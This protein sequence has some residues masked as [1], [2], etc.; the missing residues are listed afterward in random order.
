MIYLIFV[1][2]IY[3]RKK[4][5]KVGLCA[6]GKLE[7]LY[8]KE[9]VNYYKKLGYKHIYIYDNNN[10]NE[11]KF[12]TVL[13]EDIKKGFVTI[14]DYRGF[15]GSRD[16]PQFD[17]YYDCYEKYNKEYDWLSFFDF[18]EFL[19][20]KPNNI[21]IYEFLENER[22]NNCISVKINWLLY[23]DN[24][25]IYYE[26]LPIQSRFLSPLTNSSLNIHI[27]STVRGNLTI[28]YWKDAQNPHTTIHQYK[29]CSS[30]GKLIPYNS[31]FNS[32]PDYNN[33]ILRH[34]KTKTIDEY[35][36]KLK[37]GRADKPLNF[38]EEDSLEKINIFF[39]V[40]E[41]KMSKIKFIKKKLNLS[42]KLYQKLKEIL[43]K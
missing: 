19:E 32:P 23:S 37:R 12:E 36:I 21:K 38:T 40:N 33:A 22:F 5:T 8:A 41:Y 10:K 7:N 20:L 1:F 29:S 3:Q 13:N 25:L 39:T 9:Y 31:P 14:I 16:S 2:L 35:L 42:K 26:N 28:N 27:K 43:K 24:N 34:Y 6:I 15:R 17:A 11:E 4:I 30:S 18:D